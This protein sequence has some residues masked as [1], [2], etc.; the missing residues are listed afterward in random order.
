MSLIQI[1]RVLDDA[2]CQFMIQEVFQKCWASVYFNQVDKLESYLTSSENC[3]DS[4]TDPG[5][6]WKFMYHSNTDLKV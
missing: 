4:N 1:P 2:Q 6:Q 5:S 3:Q